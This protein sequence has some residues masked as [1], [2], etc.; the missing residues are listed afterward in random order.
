MEWPFDPIDVV[1]WMDGAAKTHLSE[2]SV[3][4]GLDADNLTEKENCEVGSGNLRDMFDYAK[5]RRE[6]G[7]KKD[8]TG[9]GLG[10]GVMSTQLVQDDGGGAVAGVG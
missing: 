4:W 9:K 3:H 8:Q 10:D 7:E 1:I 2:Y 6:L 5:L